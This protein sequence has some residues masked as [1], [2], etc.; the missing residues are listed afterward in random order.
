[1]RTY[2][3]ESGI[4]YHDML[5]KT[6]ERDILCSEKFRSAPVVT[7]PPNV[8]T[9]NYIETGR[10]SVGGTECDITEKEISPMAEFCE[11]AI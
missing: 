7:E 5:Q 9:R 4:D 3:S 2:L 1:M 11:G 6:F 8:P 10:R